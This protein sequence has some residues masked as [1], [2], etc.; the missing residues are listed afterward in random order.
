MIMVRDDVN[1]RLAVQY[2]RRTGSFGG[3]YLG[4]VMTRV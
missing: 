2:R 1:Q 4:N 3:G